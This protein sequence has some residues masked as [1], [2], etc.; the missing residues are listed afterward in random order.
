MRRRRWPWVLLVLLLLVAGN[1]LSHRLDEIKQ[2]YNGLQ[3]AVHDVTD[4]IDSISNRVET[5]LKA[6]NSLAADYG[7]E[8]AAS[9]LAANT[10]TF[11]V[12]A[13]PRTYVEGL[14]VEFIA[15]N[16]TETSSM[17]GRAVESTDRALF[18]YGVY[19]PD[20]QHLSFRPVRLSGR[21]PADTIA[22]HLLL[23]LHQFHVH[24]R[25]HC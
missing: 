2:Q 6:Q 22:G 25:Q 20:G 16:G 9:N 7:S 12:Y 17:V 21:Y 10:V 15:E 1:N 5:I 23:S 13:V 19:P 4:Q 8:I 3:Y 18:C 11:S 24:G 14:S